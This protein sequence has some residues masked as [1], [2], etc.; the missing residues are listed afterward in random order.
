MDTVIQ[1]ERLGVAL[2]LGLLIGLE[3]GWKHRSEAEGERIA[4]LRTFGLLGLLGGI[5]ALLAAELGVLLFAFG[6]AA[7]AVVLVL[8]HLQS[9]RA[10]DEPDRSITSLVAA[11]LAFALGGLAGI[12]YMG[13]AAAG[14]VVTALLLNLKPTLHGWLESLSRDEVTAVLKLGLISVVVLPVL[15]NRGFGPWDVLNPY[16]IWWLV[17]LIAGISFVGYFA[18]KLLGPG[19]GIPL[20]GLFGGLTSSTATTL[21]FARMGRRQHSLAPILASGIA[22]AAATM[23]PRILLEVAVVNPGLLRE[24]AP[25]M[26]AVTLLMLIGAALLWW[27]STGPVA[28]AEV[29]LKNPFEIAPALQFG[30]LLVGVLLLA[31]A[32]RQWFG[33]TGVFVLAALSGLTDVDAITL[34]MARMARG[35]LAPESAV[36][37]ILLAAA[38]NTAVKVVLAALLGHIGMAIRLAVVFAPALAGGGL[39]WYLT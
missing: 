11:L 23:F 24:L 3:R 32:A 4:G 27:R 21:S 26:T 34:S 19:R 2:A 16:A 6:F 8:V 38:V 18:M 35:D 13:P 39:V 5:L 12:G 7:L 20:T 31:E 9:V 33:D 14:A 30:A 10:R 25:A 37:A 36:G 29:K 28:S 22:V 15:P 17:V 1:F